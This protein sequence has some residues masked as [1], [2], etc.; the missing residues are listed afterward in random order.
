MVQNKSV[1][2]AQNGIQPD[3]YS[4]SGTQKVVAYFKGAVVPFF[5]NSETVGPRKLK[6][7]I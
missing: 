5:N 3:L 7:R 2:K 6:F 4:R 1:K